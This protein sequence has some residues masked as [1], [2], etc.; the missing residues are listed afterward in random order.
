M[1][2]LLPRSDIRQTSSEAGQ[3]RLDQWR[4]T[5]LLAPSFIIK[6]GAANGARTHDIHLGKVAFYQLNYR[7]ILSPAFNIIKEP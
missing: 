3:S 2:L 4:S 7:R 1:G 5:W 6:F